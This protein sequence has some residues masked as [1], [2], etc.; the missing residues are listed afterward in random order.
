MTAIS[1]SPRKKNLAHPLYSK[2]RGIKTLLAFILASA[3][4]IFLVSLPLFEFKDRQNYLVYATASDI[5]W[6]RYAD[7]GILSLFAN[8]PLWLAIN[9]LL[10]LFWEPEQVLQIII[11]LSAFSVAYTILRFGHDKFIWL[12]LVLVYPLIIKNHV[13][14]L[15][16]GI[17]IAF[18]LIGMLGIS[19]KKNWIKWILVSITPFI[20]SSFFIVLGI[21]LLVNLTKGLKFAIDL[22]IFFFSICTLAIIFLLPVLVSIFGARQASTYNWLVLN[23]VS[24]FS[25]VFWFVILT[26]FLTESKIFLRTYR[27]EI[28]MIIFYLG[29]YFFVPVTARIFESSIALII[30]S[31][32]Q[33]TGW[34]G[35]VF[36]WAMLLQTTFLW[37]TGF[38][39]SLLA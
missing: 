19:Q 17:A 18:F 6:Q 7:Q 26:V 3:Y 32:F 30:L 8:E 16:Q 33:L 27:F 15:R 37:A 10:G 39:S 20:H 23:D 4:A 9:I 14:H 25:F 36:R 24:G 29:T 22:S 21:Y 5:I 11:G 28:S 12:L 38:W 34:R 31:G 2:H 35:S 13:I 1:E